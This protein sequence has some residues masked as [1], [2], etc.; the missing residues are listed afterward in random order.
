MSRFVFGTSHFTAGAA[1]VLM[2]ICWFM[3][4][5]GAVLLALSICCT[6]GRS[7]TA[8]A[9]GL[10]AAWIIG[11]FYYQMSMPLAAKAGVLVAAAVVLASLASL[12]AHKVEITSGAVRGTVAP[13]RPSPRAAQMAIAGCAMLVLI[14]ANAGIWQK[15][16]LIAH[17]QPVFVEL[18]PVDPRSLMQGDYMR[19]NFSLPDDVAFHLN[20]LLMPGRAQVIAKR[21]GRGV[22]TLLRVADGLPLGSGEFMFELTPKDGRWILVS[23][24]WFFREGEGERWANAKYGEFRVGADGSALLVGLR[25]AD[26]QDL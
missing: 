18:V 15:E 16:D 25:G 3:P 24:A 1:F 26:L 20:H 23:D 12:G 4:S 21:D 5:L 19:L 9:A 8:S 22:A 17:G 2:V 11:A 7:V 14:A 13:V 10:A 6:S